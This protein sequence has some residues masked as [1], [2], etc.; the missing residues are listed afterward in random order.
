LL[1]KAASAEQLTQ[2]FEEYRKETKEHAARLDRIF[3]GFGES[4]ERKSGQA[5]AG[6][7]AEARETLG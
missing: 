7:V 5:M 2:A 1:A 6:L 4:S 3:K